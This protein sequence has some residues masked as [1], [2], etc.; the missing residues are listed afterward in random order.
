M[1]FHP[2]SSGV[3]CSASEDGSVKVWDLREG[4]VAQDLTSG[5]NDAVYCA[6]W[7]PDGTMIASGSAD[8]EVSTSNNTLHRIE[9][10]LC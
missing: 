3:L 6:R 4:K 5:H 7:S 2:H 8:T 10:I 1:A 9:S